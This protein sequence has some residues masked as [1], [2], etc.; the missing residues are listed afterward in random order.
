MSPALLLLFGSALVACAP[1]SLRPG[2]GEVAESEGKPGLA[3]V[4]SE[5][6]RLAGAQKAEKGPWL[7][8]GVEV[9]VQ[10]RS[11]DEI[12]FGEG[13]RFMLQ[14]PVLNPWELRAGGRARR[15]ASTQATS[16]LSHAAL[17]A[18][19][20]ACLAGSELAAAQAKQEAF[21][22]FSQLFG[23]LLQ[24]VSRQLENGLLT[25]SEALRVQVDAQTKL[26]SKE[27][28]PPVYRGFEPVALPELDAEQPPLAVDPETVRKLIRQHHPEP[29]VHES[30]SR[31][32]A[33]LAEKES[34]A[35]LPWL[36]NLRLS[37]DLPGETSGGRYGG[38]VALNFPFGGSERSKAAQ[39][40][41][42]SAAEAYLAAAKV[43]ELSLNALKALEELRFL[44]S[45]APRWHAL[46]QLAELSEA[47]VKKALSR[48]QESPSHLVSHLA[49][50]QSARQAYINARQ[51]AGLAACALLEATGVE[52]SQW[53]R[54]EEARVQ[55]SL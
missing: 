40:Q 1:P 32:S 53:P 3:R 31:Y 54:G 28:L 43:S 36:K 35:A 25:E 42:E 9:M 6:A 48:G 2:P 26:L 41:G 44:E 39:H 52:Y 29:E 11:E 7:V 5:E 12:A 10:N 17:Q 55:T 19:S 47:A 30:S 33:A 20:E 46:I 24:L 22:P 4:K 45:R 16:R 23:E 51:R 37:Y 49:D 38:R 8:D 13:T 14:V 21:A 50:A 34:A 18:K 27:P 15:E